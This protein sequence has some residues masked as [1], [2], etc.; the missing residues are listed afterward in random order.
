MNEKISLAIGVLLLIMAIGLLLFS[1][2]GFFGLNV[3]NSEKTSPIQKTNNVLSTP[4]ASAANSGPTKFSDGEVSV[5]LIPQK[6]ENGIFTVSIGVNTHTVNDLDK[7][8]LAALTTL[9][10]NGQKYR[11]S[12]APSLSGHHNLGELKFDLPR[13]PEAYTI[14]ILGLHDAGTRTFTWP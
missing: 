9:E 12:S 10:W 13:E 14:A 3:G 7:Y 11:P 4:S 1:I 6:Y 5:E 2:T 8:D